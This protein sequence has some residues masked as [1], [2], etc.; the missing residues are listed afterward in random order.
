MI[1][2]DSQASDT[3]GIATHT[4]RLRALKACEPCRERKR[5]V[6]FPSALRQNSSS[7]LRINLGMSWVS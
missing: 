2:Q 3:T 1:A 4:K 6:S 5:K 7:T